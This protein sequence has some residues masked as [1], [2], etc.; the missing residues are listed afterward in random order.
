MKNFLKNNIKFILGVIVGTVVSGSIVYAAIIASSDQVSFSPSN[1]NW[2]VSNVKTALDDLYTNA[3]NNYYTGLSAAKVGT[4]G[5]AQ[6]LTGYTFTNSSTVGASGSMTNNGAKNYTGTSNTK[7]AA[8]YHNGNGYCKLGDAY[9]SGVTAGKNS[10]TC[11]NCRELMHR[12][13]KC[14]RYDLSPNIASGS[15]YSLNVLSDY[16]NVISVFVIDVKFGSDTYHNTYY[17]EYAISESLSATNGGTLYF[18]G[19]NST[20]EKNLGISK[21]ASIL[22]DDVDDGL[23]EERFSDYNVYFKNN[24]P[25][26]TIS[27]LNVRICGYKTS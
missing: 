27:T 13:V 16:T 5:A 26:A 12:V 7:I 22:G 3:Q 10:V 25:K 17:E 18:Y 11:T 20:V 19:G 15:T 14:K 23:N 6:V 1:S 4:A 24:A 9:S 2:K 8:G 21:G